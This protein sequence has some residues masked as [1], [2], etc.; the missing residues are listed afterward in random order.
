MCH[1]LIQKV[2]NIGHI[3]RYCLRGCPSIAR[4]LGKPTGKFRNV[5]VELNPRL[6]K[7]QSLMTTF[8]LKNIYLEVY[9]LPAKSQSAGKP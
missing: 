3:G 2:F 9:P 6:S 1:H 4:S 7:E 5:V 8:A